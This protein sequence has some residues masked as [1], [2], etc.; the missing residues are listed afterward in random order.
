LVADT[1][2]QLALVPN[3]HWNNT[4]MRTMMEDVLAIRRQAFGEEH[5]D[6]AQAIAGLA[7]VAQRELD[8]EKGARLHAEALAMRRRLLGNEHPDVAASLDALG[9]SYAHELDRKSEA[10]AAYGESFAI[11][12]KV[13]GD[14]HPIMVVSLLRFA[15]QVPARAA[16]AET[17]AL[18]RG[19][20]ASQRKVLPRGSALLAPSLL[21]LASL[22]DLPDRN[23]A[24]ARALVREARAILDESRSTDSP[25]EAEVID[26]MYFFVWSKFVGNVPA[27]GLP[28]GEET[29]KLAQAAF[30]A[31]GSGALLPTHTMAW[32]YV[33]LGRYGEAAPQ[34]EAAVR[35]GRSVLGE[36][37]TIT[38]VDLAALGACYCATNRV[39]AA[40]QLLAAAL[41][42]HDAKAVQS[43]ANPPIAIV[44]G[45]YGLTLVREGRFAEAEAVLR[46]ALAEYDRNELRPLNLRLQPRPRVAS[47]LGQA[48]AGQG[49]FAE[50]E[51]LVV[52]AFQ[53]LQAN[54]ARLAGDAASMVREALEAVLALYT[55]WGRPEKVIEWQAKR[56]SPP[57]GS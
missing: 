40:R 20:V 46:Q 41:A 28:M 15:G 30:G 50:A 44:R 6:V 56:A 53:E 54:E 12:R 38:L 31:A 7:Y 5:P 55:A 19:F 57:A 47:G 1:L 21:A 32:V 37:H 17:L 39:A 4:E 8:H 43:G 45:Q 52:Q 34:F 29:L 22:E 10:A 13:L 25:I 42:S 26:A 16:N 24:E 3:S 49:R 35:L 9:F 27:E 2:Y 23:P 51:P 33:G 36:E 14:Q 18:V 48:L 11:R